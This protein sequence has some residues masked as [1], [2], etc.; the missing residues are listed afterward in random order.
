MPENRSAII[1]RLKAE[2]IIKETAS[3]KYSITN[4]GAI[5]FANELERFRSL[6]RKALRLIIFRGVNRIN[7]N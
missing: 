6:G 2:G 3:G 1:S 5:L 4:I 7:T